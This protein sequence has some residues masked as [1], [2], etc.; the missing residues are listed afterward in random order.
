MRGS[1]GLNILKGLFLS[2]WFWIILASVTFW[3]FVFK[4][5][6]P[7]VFRFLTQILTKA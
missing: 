6:N 5:V 7:V 1:W 3:Y 4:A 2:L